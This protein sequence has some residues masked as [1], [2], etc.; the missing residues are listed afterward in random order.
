MDL[1]YSKYYESLL[2]F[3]KS[4]NEERILHQVKDILNS[5]QDFYYDYVQEDIEKRCINLFN[6][7]FNQYSDKDLNGQHY[8]A[9]WHVLHVIPLVVDS[10]KESKYA[11]FFYEDFVFEHV[12]CVNCINHYMSTIVELPKTFDDVNIAFDTFFNLHNFINESNNKKKLND[13][14]NFKK[15][16]LNE[17]STL[18]PNLK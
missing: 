2:C 14:E 12:Q 15:Q 7:L 16:L 10:I 6:H 9:V 13:M 18:Y 17:I 3:F 1:K 4:N 5:P 8:K 11:V